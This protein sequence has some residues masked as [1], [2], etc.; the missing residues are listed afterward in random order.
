MR[1][2]HKDSG[3]QVIILITFLKMANAPWTEAQLIHLARNNFHQHDGQ[4]INMQGR[5]VADIMP[6]G[7]ANVGIDFEGIGGGGA[8]PQQDQ[9]QGA[10]DVF[11]ED[12]GDIRVGAAVPGGILGELNPN[13]FGNCRS[14]FSAIHSWNGYRLMRTP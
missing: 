8:N 7:L 11:D 2:N 5:H 6:F 3:I 10:G 14:V 1:S 4:T 9:G 12:F 13:R